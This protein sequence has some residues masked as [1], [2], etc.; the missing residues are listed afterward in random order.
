M[1]CFWHVQKVTTLRHCSSTWRPQPA[2]GF[3]VQ[4]LLGAAQRP[5][6]LRVQREDTERSPT[7]RTFAPQ[8]A[9]RRCARA[10]LRGEKL[11]C[12]LPCLRMRAQWSAA[13]GTGATTGRRIRRR[14]GG[15]RAQ[16]ATGLSQRATKGAMARGYIC[17]A[18]AYKRICCETRRAR[19][20]A[21]RSSAPPWRGFGDRCSWSRLAWRDR[22]CR[23]YV[24][25]SICMVRRCTGQQP[26]QQWAAVKCAPALVALAKHAVI[27]VCAMSEP[28]NVRGT[29]DQPQGCTSGS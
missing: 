17:G 14:E 15:E 21:A 9:S 23:S 7:C 22:F 12:I 26:G 18:C 1:S 20:D 27:K 3:V 13:D 16:C 2:Q 8:S 24:G 6:L 29:Q 19:G 28:A 11:F 25:R 5:Q 10:P 4:R